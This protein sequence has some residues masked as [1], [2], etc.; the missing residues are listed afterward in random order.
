MTQWLRTPQ[1]R[2]AGQLAAV[3]V[4]S[5][6]LVAVPVGVGPLAQAVVT[7][8]RSRPVGQAP[9]LIAVEPDA[10]ACVLQS[11]NRGEPVSV[12]TGETTMGG[13][14]CGSPSSIAWP[15]LRDGL[16]AAIAVD[17]PLSDQCQASARP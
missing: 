5:P 6:D 14:I 16:N 4:A 3:A 13:M 10:A 2:D 11:L 9:A 8:Y 15:Y 1:S 17:G 12:A 7:H